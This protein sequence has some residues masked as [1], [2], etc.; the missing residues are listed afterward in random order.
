MPKLP[1]CLQ[2]GYIPDLVIN[3]P[4]GSPWHMS[5]KNAQVDIHI[6]RA[7]SELLRAI[8]CQPVGKDLSQGGYSN[9]AYGPDLL[10]LSTLILS[11]KT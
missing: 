3:K 7:F 9:L 11:L 4:Q 6:L 1:E 10:Q 5:P 8:G 2:F